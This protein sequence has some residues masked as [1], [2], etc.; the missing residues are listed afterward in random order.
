MIS[1]NPSI[2]ISFGS[3]KPSLIAGEQ[4]IRE[5]KTEFPKVFSPS[6]IATR[7]DDKLDISS[8][9]NYSSN[10][11][12]KCLIKNSTLKK[13]RSQFDYSS[14]ENYLRSAI[15]LIKASNVANCNEMALIVQSKLLE[16]G[17]KADCILAKVVTN[18]GK[19]IDKPTRNHVFV[20]MDLA[21]KAVINEPKTWG[22]KAVIV[23]PWAGEFRPAYEMLEEYKKTLDVKESE[24][25]V[26]KVFK[27]TDS[28]NN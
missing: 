5:F 2:Q 28:L 1:N 25:L 27:H 12:I 23:D 22:S 13:I 16:R 4:A 15:P 24:L 20:V 8:G 10:L 21:K 11:L 7:L 18:D 6:K 14:M 3:L 9:N 26:F 19:P 17:L